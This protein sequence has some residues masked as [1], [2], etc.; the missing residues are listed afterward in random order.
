M[1]IETSVRTRRLL[2]CC[3]W[4]P[5][6]TA[7][8]VS[9]YGLVSCRWHV[10]KSWTWC[11]TWYYPYRMGG[12][13]KKSPPKWSPSLE[14][15]QW[16]VL[17]CH[18][19]FRTMATMF[20]VRSHHCVLWKTSLLAVFISS[21]PSPEFHLMRLLPLRNAFPVLPSTRETRLISRSLCHHIPL[22]SFWALSD[23][24]LLEKTH[25]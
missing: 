24:T 12:N 7:L 19:C 18:S 10:R 2:L 11:A 21:F 22:G 17:L 1:F 4:L 15:V 13:H 9:I 23:S 5:F 8:S 14:K 3:K 20:L 25:A 16:S 6:I